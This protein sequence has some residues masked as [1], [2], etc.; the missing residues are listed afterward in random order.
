MYTKYSLKLVESFHPAENMI[1]TLLET[2]NMV[3]ASKG[4]HKNNSAYFDLSKQF[5]SH[6]QDHFNALDAIEG[7]EFFDHFTDV[8]EYIEGFEDAVS[9]IQNR[10]RFYAQSSDRLVLK[11]RKLGK[12]FF[13]KIN[14]M[15]I[16]G[17]NVFRRIFKK[18]PISKTFW[19]HK[20]N[21]KQL[22]EL[23]YL[24]NF[25]DNTNQ[26]IGETL[27]FRQEIFQRIKAVDRQIEYFILVKETWGENELEKE[28]NECAELIQSRKKEIEAF[29]DQ[30][31][32]NLD[33]LYEE[34]YPKVGTIEFPLRRIQQGRLK[35]KSAR[36]L[37]IQ[38]TLLNNYQRRAFSLFEHWRLVYE[39]RFSNLSFTNH[40]IN[41]EVSLRDMFDEILITKDDSFVTLL[42]T[43][44]KKISTEE[45]LHFVQNDL[46]SEQ[47]LKQGI[48]AYTERIMETD[49]IAHLDLLNTS[50]SEEYANS[51]ESYLLP[52]KK[53]WDQDERVPKLR[54]TNVSS[55][56]RGC[57]SESVEETILK[58]KNELINS[59]QLSL[60]N[61][62]DLAGVVEY[63][64]EY[65]N[66]K[67]V[68]D[69]AD[70]HAE[71]A[72]SIERALKKAKENKQHNLDLSR[73]LIEELGKINRQF[74]EEIT[75]AILPDN[76]NQKQT[77]MIRKKRIKDA[78]NN[79]MNVLVFA[80]ELFTKSHVRFLGLIKQARIKYTAY[81]EVLGL[82]D[83]SE[84]IGSE[85]SNYLSETEKAIARLPLMYQRLF[86]IAPLTNA[87][88]RI[89]RPKVIQQFEIAYSNWTSGK[90]APTCLVGETG[91]GMTSSVNIFEEKFGHQYPFYRF[92][93]ERKIT[94]EHEFIEFLK[95]VFDDL[96]F[97]SMDELHSQIGE[98]KGRRIIIIENIH[99]LFLRKVNGFKVLPLFFRLISESNKKIFWLSTCLLYTFN[100]FD[101]TLKVSNYYGH[102]VRLENLNKDQLTEIIT[103]RHKFSGFKLNFLEAKNFNPKRSY[104]KMTESQKQDYLREDYFKRLYSYAQNNLSLALV[105]W[106]RSVVN[107]EDNNFYL[108][109]RHLDYSFFTSLSNP[110]VITLYNLLLHGCLTLEEHMAI[111]AWQKEESLDHLMVFTDDGILIKKENYYYI[112]SLVYR[113]VVN[114]L[115]VLNYIH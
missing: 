29:F 26:I 80:K 54:E 3:E 113:Q 23:V 47:L 107:V 112:N 32:R 37:K 66:T 82:S 95:T 13:L 74:I 79:V 28:L 100:Y 35:K 49:F 84:T 39:I 31:K 34:L 21:Q 25:L 46:L 44:F 92:S 24:V 43:A 57:L 52:V 83:K 81:R 1:S 114:H 15:L 16:G 19:K 41:K 6:V 27:Q 77:E 14:W 85:L 50:C 104:K 64:L 73:N 59:I 96:S 110:Q 55:I 62:G 5:S 42:E 63:A 56:V 103:K 53:A 18:S 111:L 60:S 86:K 105:F 115:D 40:F 88:F 36:Y 97:E 61:A 2:I 20:V 94:T 91:S 45:D 87:K 48:P 90:F 71:F 76:L 93:L 4:D 75:N 51:M 106:M 8:N 69:S 65:Y 70:Q 108:Q 68:E 33:A 89:E 67:D 10:E 12:L 22:A 78:R 72:N 102:I 30:L 17:V 38:N 11:I 7:T 101:Y 58:Q 98:L 109:Y 9:E 99:H